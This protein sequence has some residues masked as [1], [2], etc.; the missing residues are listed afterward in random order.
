MGNRNQQLRFTCCQPQSGAYGGYG[1][2]Q[3][4]YAQQSYGG[5]GQQQQQ[6]WA[7]QPQQW[8]Q[9]PHQYCDCP[10]Y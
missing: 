2:Q 9:Q 8:G 6:Q 1:Q 4:Q 5:Y 10:G 3:P 7:P